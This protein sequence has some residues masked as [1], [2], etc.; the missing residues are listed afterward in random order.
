MKPMTAILRIMSRG[1]MARLETSLD[2]L[3]RRLRI[4][5]DRSGNVSQDRILSVLIR[6]TR[7]L[8]RLREENAELQFYCDELQEEN[9]DLRIFLDS[10]L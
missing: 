3:C 10:I 6:C 4:P 9:Y 1:V 2:R 7:E 8:E 5:Q